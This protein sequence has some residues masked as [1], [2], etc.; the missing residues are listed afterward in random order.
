MIYILF[1]VLVDIA[2]AS[3]MCKMPLIAILK[4]IATDGQ[5]KPRYTKRFPIQN[6]STERSRSLKYKIQNGIRLEVAG[7]Q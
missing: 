4:I 2:S 1:K 5:I 6:R 7:S 3:Q